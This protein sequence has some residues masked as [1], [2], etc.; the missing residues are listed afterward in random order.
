MILT[1]GKY[2]NS[3]PNKFNPSL[4][5]VASRSSSHNIVKNIS[6]NAKV[7]LKKNSCN[8]ASSSNL[9]YSKVPWSSEPPKKLGTHIQSSRPEMWSN[10]SVEV[11][12]INKPLKSWKTACSVKS[13]KSG[14]LSETNKDSLKEDK[15]LLVQM[16]IHWKHFNCWLNVIFWFK[17]VLSVLL[18]VLK[19]LKSLKESL[20]TLCKIFIPF[21]ISNNLWLKDNF[22]RMKTWRVK[23]GTD[24][25]LNL[26]KS[27][28]TKRRKLKKKRKNTILSLQNNNQD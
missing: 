3:N 21:T 1:T 2:N 5:R 7:S 25:Y 18:A 10:W 23:I 24:S 17:V 14:H 6:N 26:N 9:T 19:M 20:S 11:Y 4:R 28:S 13:L 16:E 12:L 15:D 8:T 22:L 27:K